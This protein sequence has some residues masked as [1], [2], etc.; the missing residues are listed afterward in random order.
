MREDAPRGRGWTVR[1][2]QVLLLGYDRA[3]RE[4]H[5]ADM[6]R[7]FVERERDARRTGRRWSFL[8]CAG[9]A[10][11]TIGLGI[12]ANTAIF[13]VVRAVLLQPLP[14]EDSGELVM[15]WGEMRNRDV[16]HF[17]SSPPDFRDLR[18]Q[19][20]LLEDM[21]AVSTFSQSLTGDGDPVQ[22]DVGFVTDNFFGLLGVE[23]V[24]GRDFVPEDATPN[25]PDVQPGSPGALPGMVLLSHSLWQQRYG[26]ASDVLGAT[27]EL[28][29][30][31]AEIV[32]V[33]PPGFELLLPPHAALAP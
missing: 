28:G 33:M 7:L 4:R 10:V 6:L 32:G 21:A 11:L 3:F 20:D 16:L 24:L 15:V 31:T 27:L 9:V 1:V 29:G 8:A 22:V 25:E 26:G 19:A 17:P 5:G 23:P 14:Y 12:G 18:E 2:Y 30:A 13:S